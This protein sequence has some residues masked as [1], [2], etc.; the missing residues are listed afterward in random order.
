MSIK[1]KLK[2]NKVIG[3]IEQIERPKKEKNHVRKDSSKRT[4]FF[5]WSLILGMLF[6][7]IVSV[8]L[9]INTRSTLNETNRLVE[10]NEN[11]EVI[12]EI[13]VESAHEFLSNF[14]KEY[15]NVPNESEALQ[16]RANKLKEYMVFNDTFNNEKNPLYNL[17]EVKG[18]RQLESFNLFHI[19]DEG[20]RN[21]FQYKVTFKNELKT[22]TEKEV[23][24][25]KGK[26]KK[27]EIEVET[28][29]EEKKT[30]LLLNIPIVYENGLFSVQS[31]PYF[32]Q[33]PSLVGNIEYEMPAIELE[34]YN[35][36]E[37]ENINEFLITFF[38]KYATEPVDEMAYLM[39]DP[40]TLNGSFLFEDIRNL[41]IYVDGDHYKALMEVVFRDELTNI[42]QVNP[43]EMTI[44]K[45]GRNFY[46]EN[47]IY[48]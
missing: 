24:K 33:I 37:I 43:V 22:E 9:S 15:I 13:P 16:G 45:N 32:T 38:E 18:T 10:A 7:A 20:N 31:V 17:E 25:G 29:T 14:I 28:E 39:D 5:I 4:A 36:N 30:S 46:V 2:K 42:E 27:K 1:D 11:E 44:S 26:E 3:K 12:E 19:E 23:T 41:K 8:L 35:G 21:L 34:E 40:Q 48:N 47:F 6:L